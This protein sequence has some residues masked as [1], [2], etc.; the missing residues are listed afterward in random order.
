MQAGLGLIVSTVERAQTEAMLLLKETAD[1][2]A[3]KVS[4][5]RGLSQHRNCFD[6]RCILVL[7]ETLA[8]QRTN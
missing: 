5:P 1:M 4:V 3:Q 2:P 6:I 8:L 7:H